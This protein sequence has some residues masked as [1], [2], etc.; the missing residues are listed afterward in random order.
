MRRCGRCQR[1]PPAFDYASTA[2]TY[3]APIDRWVLRC[4]DQH[5]LHWHDRLNQLTRSHF[6]PPTVMPDAVTFIPSSRYKRLR[7]GFN[8]SESLAASV[9]LCIDRPLLSLFQL[10]A[11][12]DQRGLSVAQRHANLQHS[13]QCL[14]PSALPDVSE[15]GHIL[16]VDD[17]MTSGATMHRA[18]QLLKQSGVKLVGCWALARA[19]KSR[20]AT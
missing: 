17:I 7:R 10:Q 9:A 11:Q 15:F 13:L 1:R 18:A 16:V 20:H 8:L 3:E 4:K 5:S 2:F 14:P 6:A 19:T 12:Q